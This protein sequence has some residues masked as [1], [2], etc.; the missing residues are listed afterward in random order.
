MKHC[1]TIPQ[2]GLL[3]ILFGF[4]SILADAANPDFANP[5][6]STTCQIDPDLVIVRVTDA[7]CPGSNDGSI[8]V[9]VTGSAPFNICISAGCEMNDDAQTQVLKTQTATYINLLPGK[10]LI[11][12]TD[13][14]GCIYYECFEVAEPEPLSYFFNYEPIYCSGHSTEVLVAGIGGT[15]PYL[16]VDHNGSELARFNHE[17]L[18]TGVWAGTHS[19]YL[20]DSKA[21]TPAQIDFSLIEPTP[22][23]ASLLL[24]EHGLCFGHESGSVKF[25]VKGGAPPYVFNLGD[26]QEGVLTVENL[27]AGHHTLK[28]GDSKN[29]GPGEITFEIEEPKELEITVVE[30]NSA[31][32]D[33]NT[34]KVK[35]EIKGG[36]APFYVSMNDECEPDE[37]AKQYLY[38]EEQEIVFNG[39]DPGWKNINVTDQNGCMVT[40][41]IVIDIQ[42]LQIELSETLPGMNESGTNSKIAVH[43]YPNPFSENAYVEF[44]IPETRNVTLEVFSISGLRIATLFEGHINAF[45]KQRFNLSAESLPNGIYFCKLTIENK[46]ITKRII[47]TR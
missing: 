11:S 34:G 28:V 37:G 3:L 14:N 30:I 43:I 25:S 20:H 39:L 40:K 45:E 7:S 18:I 16:L 32:S 36:T 12:V 44:V 38:Y 23:I 22:V 8:M 2:F 15:P 21:C 9:D 29:C 41:C 35:M 26:Y 1:K 17:A 4:Q 33:D 46:V 42:N 10:Y 13:A 24:I 27:S 6:A 31:T 47:L 19:W 5:S